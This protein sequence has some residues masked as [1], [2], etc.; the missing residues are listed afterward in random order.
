MKRNRAAVITTVSTVM[1]GAGWVAG[2]V[3]TA[4]AST[5]GAATIAALGTSDAGGT[6][7]APSTTS[8]TSASPS[9]SAAATDSTAS[10]SATPAPVATTPAAVSGTFD[11]AAVKTRYGTYQVEIIVEAGTISNVV[12]LQ[13]GATDRESL[14]I[15]GSALPQLI[16]AVLQQQ[17]F[18][19]SYVS[20]ASYTSQG[21]AVSV[22]DAM[23]QAGLA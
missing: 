16:S 2:M 19:V 13:T 18:N 4:F 11:G 17:T 3:G 14:Q 12:M 20:G 8:T 23:T 22:Q 7:V 5:N 9:A 10:A 15:S 6:T 1:L 21:F